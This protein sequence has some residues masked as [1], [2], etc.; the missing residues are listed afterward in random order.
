MNHY[1]YFNFRN[2]V[3]INVDDDFFIGGAMGFWVQSKVLERRMGC[4]LAT[5]TR[6]PEMN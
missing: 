4:L 3:A 5:W 1:K 2:F 6:V